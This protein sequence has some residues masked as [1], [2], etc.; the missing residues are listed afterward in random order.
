MKHV[1][2]RRAL[3]KSILCDLHIVTFRAQKNKKDQKREN[4]EV[5]IE[6]TSIVDL[7]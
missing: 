5:K 3:R 1:D 6:I 7:A 4:Y 2:C